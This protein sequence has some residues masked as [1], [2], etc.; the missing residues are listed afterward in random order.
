[1]DKDY[2]NNIVPTQI[3][4]NPLFYSQRREDFY[5]I[6]LADQREGV[7]VPPKKKP[8]AEYGTGSC[9]VFRAHSYEHLHMNT[10]LLF[11]T[12]KM[13]CTVE[14][15]RNVHAVHWSII[16]RDAQSCSKGI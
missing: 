12:S 15:T 3:G 9:N 6:P 4:K 5:T 16:V 14:V 13:K 2:E 1:M 11:K 7:E 8:P 10:N